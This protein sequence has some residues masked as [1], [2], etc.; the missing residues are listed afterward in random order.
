M[1]I[2]E[3]A[4]LALIDSAAAAHM[5]VGEVLTNL[6]AAPVSD[7]KQVVFRELDG[8]GKSRSRR[9]RIVSSGSCIAQDF[10]TELGIAI[11]SEDSLSMKSEWK[12]PG[13]TCQVTSPVSLVL[14][15]LAPLKDVPTR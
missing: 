14:S 7:L 2:G 10:C 4:P 15:A 11:P 6:L 3:K 5:T 9:S 8:C 13:N 12:V 1:A